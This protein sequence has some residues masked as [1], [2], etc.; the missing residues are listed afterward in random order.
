VVSRPGGHQFALLVKD[1]HSEQVVEVARRLLEGLGQPYA[2]GIMVRSGASI[3]ITLSEYGYQAPN[4]MLRD[5]ESA[6]SRA[7]SL[8]GARYVMHH[9]D[10][11]QRTSVPERNALPA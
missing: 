10:V 2:V 4:D 5:A 7:K 1:V 8:G 9:P 11:L 3:G 6:M